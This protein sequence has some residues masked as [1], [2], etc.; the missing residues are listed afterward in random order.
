MCF[1]ICTNHQT[2]QLHCL[3]HRITHLPQYLIKC[4][5]ACKI[6]VFVTSCTRWG[7]YINK[8]RYIYWE[9]LFMLCFEHTSKHY[10]T[11][12]HIR[13]FVLAM[14]KSLAPT[15][16]IVLF[17]EN[18]KSARSSRSVLLHSHNHPAPHQPLML[19]FRVYAPPPFR[20]PSGSP[21]QFRIFFQPDIDECN[22]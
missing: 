7:N 22:C 19:V 21:V 17:F 16:R 5:I 12:F 6:V 2:I 18:L 20:V 4:N 11:V 1:I 8:D 3:Q 14:L 13:S 9:F 10:R 15:D